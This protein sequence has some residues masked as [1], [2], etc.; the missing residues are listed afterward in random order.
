M[1]VEVKDTCVK[2][3]NKVFGELILFLNRILEVLTKT[4]E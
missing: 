1:T 3:I 4:T 2:V